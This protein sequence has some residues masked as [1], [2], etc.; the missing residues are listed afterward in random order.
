MGHF[1]LLL[2]IF[3]RSS[4][5]KSF[6]SSL[7]DDLLNLLGPCQNGPI[8]KVRRVSYSLTRLIASSNSQSFDR[9]REASIDI[10]FGEEY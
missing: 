3:K 9:S 7:Q 6:G 10:F 2:R 1:A 4:F 8:N 5:A